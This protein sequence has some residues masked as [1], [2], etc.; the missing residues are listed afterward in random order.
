VTGD[1]QPVGRPATRRG[2]PRPDPTV[3]CSADCRPAPSNWRPPTGTAGPVR[4]GLGTPPCPTAD[5]APAVAGVHQTAG[6]Q[7]IFLAAA[8]RPGDGHVPGP[9]A[10]RGWVE[11]PAGVCRRDVEGRSGTFSPTRKAGAALPVGPSWRHPAVL[12]AGGSKT[13]AVGRSVKGGRPVLFARLPTGRAASTFSRDDDRPRRLVI[14]RERRRA[15]RVRAARLWPAGARRAWSDAATHRGATR[16]WSSPAAW[17]Q[18]PPARPTRFST[19]YAHHAGVYAGRRT[20]A[21]PS[22]RSVA[23]GSG[24]AVLG[25]ERCGRVFKGLNFDR[26]GRPRPAAWPALIQEV[27]P[28]VSSHNDDRAARRKPDCACPRAGNKVLS[29]RT[30]GFG[31]PARSTPAQGRSRPPPQGVRLVRDESLNGRREAFTMNSTHVPDLPVGPPGRPPR[32]VGAVLLAA[33]LCWNGL[34]AQ[35]VRTAARAARIVPGWPS[36]PSRRW[37]STQ[38]EVGWRSSG[39]TRSPRSPCLWDDSPR[40]G[41]P[42]TCRLNGNG[43]FAGVAPRG[44]RRA[45]PARG[46]VGS[47]CGEREDERHRAGRSRRPGSGRRDRPVRA[48]GARRPKQGARN[49]VGVVADFRTATGTKGRPPCRPATMLRLKGRAGVLRAGGGKSDA[50][51]RRRTPQPRGR[52]RSASRAKAVAHP[53]HHRKASLPRGSTSRR[54]FAEERTTATR[55][56]RR[57]R[58]APM[59]RT[60]GSLLWKPKK[61]K[62]SATSR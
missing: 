3:P 53:V 62:K 56:R 28:A 58:I 10:G 59:G 37:A 51:A 23:G 55:S 43:G 29:A 41:H 25:D 18:G 14:G 49:L 47:R 22:N 5:A 15:V 6:G 46:R 57:S 38:P 42:A 13:D 21:W 54:F 12:R 33:G 45:E 39:P 26:I 32:P 4:C 50:A 11:E 48:A 7:V 1:A 8:G 16:R 17:R 24:R 60:S 44:D 19:E 52:Q 2:D 31:G 20:A 27:W 9:P 30:T 36:S 35:R 34:A 40:H 61:K